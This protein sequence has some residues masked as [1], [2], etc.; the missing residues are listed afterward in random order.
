MEPKISDACLRQVEELLAQY[1]EECQSKNSG[2]TES[3]ALTYGGGANNFVRWIR[4]DFE[5]GGT[6]KP[7]ESSTKT[8]RPGLFP[9]PEDDTDVL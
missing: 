4:G 2:L 3:A 5:P 1:I 9:Q 8:A 7:P 6:L